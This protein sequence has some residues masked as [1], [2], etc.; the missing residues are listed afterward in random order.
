M[1]SL[2]PSTERA[3]SPALLAGDDEM[4]GFGVVS[5]APARP[6]GGPQARVIEMADGDARVTGRGGILSVARGDHFIGGHFA[7]GRELHGGGQVACRSLSESCEM[8]RT[9]PGRLISGCRLPTA[10]AGSA[11]C[12]RGRKARFTCWAN[13]QDAF[14]IGGGER[15]GLNAVARHAQQL[16]CWSVRGHV[17]SRG[18]GRIA[19]ERGRQQTDGPA[20]FRQPRAQFIRQRLRANGVPNERSQGAGFCGC[21]ASIIADFSGIRETAR[22]RSWRRSANSTV[23]FR[24]PSLSPAS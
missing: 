21:Q 22:P 11:R 23:A 19:L 7:R 14:T 8:P 5:F 15:R 13:R 2:A 4:V 24:N 3:I 17:A 6:N 20:L 18:I 16:R 10:M 9:R 12:G 1:A